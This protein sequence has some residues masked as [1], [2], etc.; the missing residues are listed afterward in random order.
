M[1]ERSACAQMRSDAKPTLMIN[2]LELEAFLPP[3]LSFF[4]YN[5]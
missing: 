1:L 2:R 5:H 4:F 3:V